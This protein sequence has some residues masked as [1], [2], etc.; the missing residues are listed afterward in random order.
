IEVAALPTTSSATFSAR[1][2]LTSFALHGCVLAVLFLIP[3]G[4][5][6]SAHPKELDVVFH[7]ETPR[8]EVPAAVIASLP[9]HAAPAPGPRL[10]RVAPPSLPRGP[11]VPQEPPPAAPGGPI[12][13]ETPAYVA[14]EPTPQQKI[15]NAG[16]L[17]FRD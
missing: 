5:R 16:I 8:I 6:R 9:Q 11:R 14:P 2:Q 10:G 4:A 1:T 15:A 12:P 7:R 13:E 3:S 17:A